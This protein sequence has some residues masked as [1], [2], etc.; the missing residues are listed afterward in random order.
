MQKCVKEEHT[1][2]SAYYYKLEIAF[3][4]SNTPHIATVQRDEKNHM[5]SNLICSEN[6]FYILLAPAALVFFFTT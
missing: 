3:N 2:L 1:C 6:L 5:R 4:G